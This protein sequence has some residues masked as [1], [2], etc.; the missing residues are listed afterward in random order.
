M[1]KHPSNRLVL[2]RIRQG[3]SLDGLA[4]LM[5]GDKSAWGAAGNSIARLV[6]EGRGEAM[7]PVA[8]VQQATA[9]SEGVEAILDNFHLEDAETQRPLL[10]ELLRNDSDG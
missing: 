6:L 9:S 1:P 4:A 10:W 5:S 2:V 7:V 8:I 3:V